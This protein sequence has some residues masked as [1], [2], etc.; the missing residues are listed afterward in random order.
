M[1]ALSQPRG[2]HHGGQRDTVPAGVWL[3]NGVRWRELSTVCG[4]TDGRI[5]WA[6]PDEF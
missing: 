1:E 4:A 2:S 6:G 3:Y 5:A